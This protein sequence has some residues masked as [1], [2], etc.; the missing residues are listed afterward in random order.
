MLTKNI[1][2]INLDHRTDRKDEFLSEMQKCN[3]PE[4]EIRRFSAIKTNPGYIGCSL[5]HVAVLTEA[6]EKISDQ[7]EFVVIFEDDFVWK[8]SVDTINKVLDNFVK[9]VQDWDVLILGAPSY[10]FKTKDIDVPGVKK[11]LSAQTTTGYIIRVKYI[12]NL[13]AVFQ[14]SADKLKAGEPYSKW[15]AD[16]V[17]KKLQEKDNWFITVPGLGKQRPSYSDIENKHVDY[18]SFV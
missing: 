1:Y 16:Q 3:I 17:W 18:A 4:S 2:Y 5:S 12:P 14:E 10:D 13:I 6:F 11:C 9:L 7:D 15:A 8:V